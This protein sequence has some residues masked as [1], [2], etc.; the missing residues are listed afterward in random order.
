MATSVGLIC[1]TS[2]CPQQV[3]PEHHQFIAVQP[4]QRGR[5]LGPTSSVRRNAAK[6]QWKKWRGPRTDG[7]KFRAGITSNPESVGDTAAASSHCKEVDVRC[8]QSLEQRNSPSLPKAAEREQTLLEGPQPLLLRAQIHVRDQYPSPLAH[9][10]V[11]PL[12]RF[13]QTMLT[14]SFECANSSRTTALVREAIIAMLE[15]SA[16]FHAVLYASPTLYLFNGVSKDSSTVQNFHHAAGLC[17]ALAIKEGNR[18]VSSVLK[19]IDQPRRGD[20]ISLLILALCLS[21]Q[22]DVE[23]LPTSTMQQG[24]R[25]APFQQLDPFL[26]NSIPRFDNLHTA[27]TRRLVHLAGGLAR[28]PGCAQPLISVYVH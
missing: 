25:Q 18:L 7:G 22:P 21:M 23:Q 26:V 17:R 12:V 13:H 8:R 10:T 15:D 4:N 24:P 19:N 11:V 28:V 5:W 3:M 27:T 9:D 6:H 2:Q 20:V 1:R 14:K 16:T